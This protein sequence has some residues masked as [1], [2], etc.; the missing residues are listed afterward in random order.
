MCE[1]IPFMYLISGKTSFSLIQDQDQNTI[2][3]ISLV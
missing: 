3:A 2:L 1:E